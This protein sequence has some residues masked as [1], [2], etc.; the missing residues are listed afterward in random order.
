MPQIDEME[1]VPDEPVMKITGRDVYSISW[2]SIHEKFDVIMPNEKVVFELGDIVLIDFVSIPVSYH[3]PKPEKYEVVGICEIPN[4]QV[5]G[6][7]ATVFPDYRVKLNP[8]YE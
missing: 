5:D 8:I 2:E 4:R 3:P 1:G 7:E 6:I